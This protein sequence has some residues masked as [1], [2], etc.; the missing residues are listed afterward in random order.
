VA[1]IAAWF[2]L[3][4]AIQ[5]ALH[6]CYPHHTDHGQVS[7]HS[8]TPR[9]HPNGTDTASDSHGDHECVACH[10]GLISRDLA[11]DRPHFAPPILAL[12]IVYRQSAPRSTLLEASHLPRGPPAA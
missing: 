11:L 12:P 3:T 5:P 2:Y 7:G 10:L 6:S 4:A 8:E 9:A 1:L